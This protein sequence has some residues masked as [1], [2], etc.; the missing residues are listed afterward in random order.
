[1]E[2]ILRGFERNMN[3]LKQDIFF[4]NKIFFAEKFDNLR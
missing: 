2:T 3:F 4:L 1:M